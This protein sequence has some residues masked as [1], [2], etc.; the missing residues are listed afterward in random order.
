[1]DTANLLRTQRL[2]EGIRRLYSYE[3]LTDLEIICQD[4][5]WKV[6]KL[7]LCA[8]SG[9]FLNACRGKFL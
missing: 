4:R 7:C 8:Q 5:V 2:V 9:F 6:H 1:M 3:E